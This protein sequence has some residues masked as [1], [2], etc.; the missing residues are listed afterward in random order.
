[1]A[2]LLSAGLLY[3]T[4]AMHSLP[5]SG[6]LAFGL[7]RPVS[8]C[9]LVCEHVYHCCLKGEA[10]SYVTSRT[11]LHLHLQCSTSH[12]GYRLE[13]CNNVPLLPQPLCQ[14]QLCCDKQQAMLLS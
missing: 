12:N 1:M 8:V 11:L 3:G 10:K 14:H 5:A 6:M 7:L 2:W 13:A 9:G 4:V